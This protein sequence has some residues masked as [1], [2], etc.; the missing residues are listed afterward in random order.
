MASANRVQFGA[1]AITAVSTTAANGV[2]IVAAN[3]QTIL[4]SS[5]ASASAVRTRNGQASANSQ[6][7]VIIAYERVRTT[8]AASQSNSAVTANGTIRGILIPFPAASTSAAT[9]AGKILW[10]PE[11]ADPADW[12]NVSESASDWTEVAA[13]SETWTEASQEASNWTDVN[14]DP[15]T[16]QRIS[17][18]GLREAA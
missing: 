14:E 7:G 16:W 15:A 13:L 3:P 9:A 1:A 18:T 11:G 12:S 6:S 10:T 8:G 4:A 2:F 17:A 5:A